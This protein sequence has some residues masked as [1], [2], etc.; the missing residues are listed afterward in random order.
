[1]PR[2][3]LAEFNTH[4]ML[5]RNSASSRA[6]PVEKM[7]RA[8]L[9]NPYIPTH[10]GKNQK[11][12]QAEVEVDEPTAKKSEAV[13]LH[14]RDRAV[15]A[16]YKLLDCGIH[17]QITN[18]LLEPFMY[19]TAITSGTEWSNFFHLRNNPMAHPDIQVIAEMMQEEHARAEPDEVGYGKWHCPLILAADVLEACSRVEPT[20]PDTLL[21][22]NRTLEL[23][24]RVG[25]L[26]KK[27]SV[28]RC[29]RVSYLTHDGKRDL[30]VDL[31]MHD[32]LLGN[33]HMS[34]FE[35]IARPMQ[36][37]DFAPIRADVTLGDR[38]KMDERWSGKL[39]GWVPYRALIP[40]ESDILNPRNNIPVVL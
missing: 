12:M 7:I 20:L 4:C 11:G 3:I 2:I 9:E 8:V 19:H 6:I 29:A 37:N 40:F 5:S 35:H 38:A 21:G 28:A 26:L 1:M 27:V 32:S 34:P 30:Q 13:W 15:E 17:K 10:W 25:E 23:N 39:R 36:L 18:R 33:G 14:A 24:E 16:A 22:S 31:G